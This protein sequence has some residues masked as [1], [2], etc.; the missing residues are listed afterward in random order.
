[1]SGIKDKTTSE[2]K[3]KAKHYHEIMN[4]GKC[5]G[6]KEIITYSNVMKELEK[7]GKIPYTELKFE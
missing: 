4:Y 2:L 1:M 7:R 5:R 3:E 6:R